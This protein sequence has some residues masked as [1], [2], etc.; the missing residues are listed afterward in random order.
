MRSACIALGL[1]AVSAVVASA[2]PPSSCASKFVG[3]WVYA[4]GTTDV[5]ADGTAYPHCPNCVPLQTWTCDGN[6]YLFSNSGP[7]GQ[8]T[9]TLVAP[10]RMQGPTW[11]ATR[12]G[13]APSNPKPH[14]EDRCATPPTGHAMQQ[15]NQQCITATN[16]NSNPKCK[17][18]FSYISSI[19]GRLGG[20]LVNAGR[21]DVSVCARPGET[22]RFDRWHQASPSAL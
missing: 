8:F 3:T 9:G 12:V 4:G 15:G 5:R 10:N 22:L 11:T 17:Y 18:S 21:T 14:S 20:P 6:T 19:S 7:P 13:G 2:A 16:T 1:M